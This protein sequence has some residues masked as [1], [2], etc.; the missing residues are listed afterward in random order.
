MRLALVD[1]LLLPFTLRVCSTMKIADFGLSMFRIEDKGHGEVDGSFAGGAPTGGL[2]VSCMAGAP[3]PR[4]PPVEPPAPKQT[5]QQAF[6]TISV[7]GTS[8]P[9]ARSF[10]CARSFAA[11]PSSP[12]LHAF[13]KQGTPAD[14]G[15]ASGTFAFVAPEVWRGATFSDPADVYAFG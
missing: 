14:A 9:P 10:A 4:Q 2:E 13:T 1:R 11:D 5:L 12:D 6:R 7:Y 8:P 3:T 15:D